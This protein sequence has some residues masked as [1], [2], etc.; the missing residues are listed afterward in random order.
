MTE[1]SETAA[2]KIPTVY[3]IDDSATMREVIKIAFRCE[4][5]RVIACHDA[6]SALAQF[7]ETAPDAVITDVIMP[8]KDGYEVCRLIKQDANL[9]NTPVIL[10][11]GV[12]D[13]TVAEKAIA[14]RADELIRKPFQ[15]RDLIARVK[16]LLNPK[17]QAASTQERP[18]DT[19]PH[20][21]PASLSGIFAPPAERAAVPWT[22]VAEQTSARPPARADGRTSTLAPIE[23]SAASPVELQKLR[24]EIQRIEMLVRKLQAELEAERQYVA[25]LEAHVRKLQ[26]SK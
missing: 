24:L 23:T 16:N 18:S 15:P 6:A 17:P 3:F 14:A 10:M 20:S 13:R 7:S 22:P 2:S 4:S 26:E 19:G 9:G 8:G 5:M 1:T 12:V 25:S 21:A 11:S